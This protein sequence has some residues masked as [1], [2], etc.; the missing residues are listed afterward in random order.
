[1]KQEMTEV[2]MSMIRKRPQDDNQK[3]TYECKDSVTVLGMVSEK[4]V[5]CVQVVR[6][7]KEDRRIREDAGTVGNLHDDD[8]TGQEEQED[9]EGSVDEREIW[10]V[11]DVTEE[12]FEMTEGETVD[13]Y[14]KNSSWRWWGGPS[15]TMT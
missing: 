9:H 13:L 4:I 10:E 5:A 11:T 6:Q 2:K 7:P 12:D 14:D 1:V 8:S 15:Q 3:K